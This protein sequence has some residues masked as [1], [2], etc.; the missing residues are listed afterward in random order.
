MDILL[1]AMVPV[2]GI[3]V[4][5]VTAFMTLPVNARM[6]MVSRIAAG[7]SRELRELEIGMLS[8]RDRAIAVPNR[9]LQNA[10]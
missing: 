3:A 5:L 1:L 8:L 10:A 7:D 2:A 6:A 4:L 9:H